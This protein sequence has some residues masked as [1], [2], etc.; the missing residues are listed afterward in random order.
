[1]NGNSQPSKE[2]LAMTGRRLWAVIPAK[3]WHTVYIALVLALTLGNAGQT[4]SAQAAPPGATELSFFMLANKEGASKPVCIGEL[5]HINVLVYRLKTVSGV[6]Q[7][8]EPVTGLSVIGLV[9]NP[10]I[11]QLSPSENT[12]SWASAIYPGAADFVFTAENYGET[13]VAFSAMIETPGWFGTN[14]GGAS[15]IVSA[16]FDI[17]VVPCKYKVTTI[18]EWHV[19]GPANI[20]LAA[21]SDD[22][23]VKAADAQGPFTGSTTVNWAESHS[24]VGNC[25]ASAAVITIGNS[26]VEWTGK[27]DDNGQLTLHAAYQPAQASDSVS[28]GESG[29]IQFQLTPDP[30]QISLASS[31]GVFKQSLL[32]QGPEATPGFVTIIVV[33][34][35]DEAMVFNPGNHVASWDDFSSWFGFLLALR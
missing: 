27:M 34:E 15:Q 20:F 16:Q 29:T 22:A 4:Y 24:G 31:G 33:P 21:T 13:I 8:P 11:G 35:E 25:P 30:I 18:G 26:R 23:E 5:V 9:D 6:S 3:R 28:C 14:W 7:A 12:T 2:S 19:P 10:S 32:L 17:R 1:M